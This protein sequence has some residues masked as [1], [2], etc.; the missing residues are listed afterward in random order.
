MAG[1]PPE[2]QAIYTR[3]WNGLPLVGRRRA[4]RQVWRGV[5]RFLV[6]TQLEM[7]MSSR[8]VARGFLHPDRLALGHGLPDFDQRGVKV[9]VERVERTRVSDDHV[10]AVAAAG[11][12]DQRLDAV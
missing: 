12:A 7:Q 6:D 2:T 9:A 10:V 3:I 5:H 1:K 8:R 11:A 4:R